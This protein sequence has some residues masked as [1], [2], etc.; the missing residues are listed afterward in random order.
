ML[1]RLSFVLTIALAI[2]GCATNATP[3]NPNDPWEPGNRQVYDFND[4]LDRKVLAPAA[5]GYSAVTPR[6]VRRGVTNFFNNV[7][8]P[9]VIVNSFLQGKGRQGLADTGRFLINTTLGV[10]G[11]FD[12]ATPLGLPAN[13]EDFGQTFAVWGANSGPY[14]VLPG[15]GPSTVRDSMDIPLAIALNPLT[16]L[17]TWG[18]GIPLA[19]LYAI[20]TR[21]ELDQA[22]RFRD[23]AAFDPY[24]F[25][26]AAYLQHRQNLIYDGNPPLD[27][28]YD[29]EYFD[30][31]FD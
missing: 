8:Y 20:N 10:V 29:D 31:A 27:E 22:A 17:A 28:L 4:D 9:K 12:V 6:F 30:E 7:T 25:T 15:Y 18:V 13:N 1:L 11:L 14:L 24:V 3:L 23:E 2:S 5:S 19:A 26:R 21:A 16:Y